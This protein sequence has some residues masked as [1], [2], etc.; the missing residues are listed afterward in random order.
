MKFQKSILFFV[1]LCLSMVSC[2]KYLD[3]V[4]DNVAT[5]D[6]AFRQRSNAEQY[7]FTCY[8]YMP[9]HGDVSTNPAFMAADEL[10]FFYP[11][12]ISGYNVN[13]AS[14][15][16]AR[17]TQ[18]VTSPLMSYWN[19]TNGAP[20]LFKAIRDCNI[21][22]ENI[23]SVP[24]MDQYEKDQWSA[25]ANF[26]KAYY[27]W[28]LLRMY[29]PIPVVDKNL[30]INASQDEVRVERMPVDSCFSYVT[31]TIDKAL[32]NLPETIQDQAT[33]M[34]RITRPI[35]LAVKAQILMT[36]ASPLFNGN[37]SYASFKNKTG[38]P[39]FNPSADRQKWLKAA[40]ACK[41]AIDIC[42]STGAKLNH[43]A[44]AVSYQLPPELQTEMDI[45]TAVTD[46]FNSE[47]IWGNTNSLASSIQG[48]AQPRPSAVNAANFSF[49]SLSSVPLNIV[50]MFYTKNGVPI[51]EDK[52]L[53][54][55][56]RGSGTRAATNNDK[57]YIQPAY[58]TASVNF[59]RE[60]RFYADLGF[61]GSILF[62]NGNL[63]IASLNHLEAKQGQYSGWGGTP[64]NYNITGYWPVKVVNYQNV[65]STAT[66]YT[67]TPYAWPVIRLA[68]LY[69]L[70]SEALNEVDGP[71][72]EAYKWIDQVRA[73]AGIPSVQNAWANY[74][75]NP[76]KYTTRDGF[77]QIIHRE[78]LIELA[79]EGQRFWDLLRWKE[80]EST[81]Q[82]PIQGWNITKSDLLSY[83]QP[84]TLFQRTF[85]LRDYF[86][87][88]AE[89]DLQVNK[90]LVQNPGW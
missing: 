70:Y 56:T 52:T 4:P 46:N 38:Q 35:A 89:A 45:R 90:K 62:G 87:P 53:D 75:N 26:L 31:Q 19:G 24:D 42:M 59:D 55:A 60:P 12:S 40:N 15:E 16:I 36:A 20:N 10:W 27:H 21:F 48:M 66:T 9:K 25:E 72:P 28:W 74:S 58:T 71:S 41:E 1:V 43:F 13:V 78:R 3:V 47:V 29:G 79:F 63:T 61:D 17:G 76:G 7:L 80:A 34:G 8:S 5:I 54:F 50:S 14:W 23:N 11:Y 81:W 6:Y 44:P 88:I 85:R 51:T 65:M 33:Q 77:R 2:K 82:E 69:L 64:S 84:A 49:L 37:T 22:L 39:F 67:I 57:Y 83:Y 18:S 86:W 73:R 30:P 32:A 68:D